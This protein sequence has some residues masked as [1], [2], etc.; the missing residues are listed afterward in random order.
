MGVDLGVGEIAAGLGAAGGL[1]GGL[2]KAGGQSLAGQTAYAQEQYQ[3]AQA[4]YQA[5]VSDYQAAVAENNAKVAE[6][7]GARTIAGAMTN[8]ATEGLKAG[9]TVGK[10]KANQAASG[11]DVN[12]GSAVDVRADA[13]SAGVFNE[14]NVLANA[15][16]QNWGYRTVAQNFRTQG[17]LDTSQANLLRSNAAFYQS[18]APAAL[19]GAGLAATGTL[20]SSASALP[21]GWLGDTAG[22]AFGSGNSFSG[23]SE[24]PASGGDITFATS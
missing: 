15:Q 19:Q 16:L 21:W 24:S 8:V 2:T 14:E 23:A 18:Q 1:L 22:K 17:A 20:L 4:G 3:A 9:A 6:A 11:I 7:T 13:A 10:I 12:T 5:Q